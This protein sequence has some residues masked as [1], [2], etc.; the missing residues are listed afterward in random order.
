MIATL[1]FLTG[2]AGAAGQNRRPVIVFFYVDGLQ[3]GQVEKETIK[4]QTLARFEENYAAAYE[5]RSGDG[6]SGVNRFTDL[7]N[8][9]RFDLL[10]RLKSDK[11]DYAVFYNLLPFST[12]KDSLFQLVTT[13]SHVHVRVFDLRKNA[14]VSDVNLSYSSQWAWPGGHCEKLYADAD[15]K[16]F[17]QL[18]CRGI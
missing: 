14:Y 9:D 7:E 15:S 16:V 1:V 18:F 17:R 11:V 12:K 3:T 6:Y 8:L 2:A 10:P 4:R 5:L 13:V